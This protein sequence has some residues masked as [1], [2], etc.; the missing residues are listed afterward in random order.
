MVSSKKGAWLKD[1][2]TM[3]IFG[4][5]DPPGTCSPLT[6]ALSSVHG[7]PDLS[8]GGKGRSERKGHRISTTLFQV[9]FQITPKSK[10]SYR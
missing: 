4:Q 8:A 6:G 5:V 2:V 9:K 1:G 7:Q 10:Y 3:V